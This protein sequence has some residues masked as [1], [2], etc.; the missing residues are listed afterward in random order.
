MASRQK[1][2][3]RYEIAPPGIILLSGQDIAGR[4][5][6]YPELDEKGRYRPRAK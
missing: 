1:K 2:A 5:R 3:K 4:R 6:L